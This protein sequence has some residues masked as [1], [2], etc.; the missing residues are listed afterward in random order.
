M[1]DDERDGY[2]IILA[3]QIFGKAAA[4][5]EHIPPEPRAPDLIYL[6]LGKRR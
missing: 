5:P 3:P 1:A 2:K 4:L 6:S